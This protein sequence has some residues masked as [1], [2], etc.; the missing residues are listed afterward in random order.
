MQGRRTQLQAGDIEPGVRYVIA[1]NH[2]TWLDAWMVLSCI[3]MS[4]WRVIGFPR[5]FASNRFFGYPFVGNYV[6]SMGCFPAKPHPTDPYGLDYAAYL[7]DRGQSVLIFP[8]GHITLNRE[9]SARQGVMVLARQ[10]NVRIIPMHFEWARPRIRSR[11]RLGIGKAFDG[12][13][14]SAEEI[15]DAIYKVPIR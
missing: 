4:I 15:L 6:R 10:A 14:M 13:Q 5:V 7:L 1:S 8:E 3:P 12:S 9:N 2:Q 11:F